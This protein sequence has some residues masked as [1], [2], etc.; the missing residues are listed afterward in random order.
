[1]KKII[2]IVLV[3]MVYG[4]LVVLLAIPENKYDWMQEI[5]GGSSLTLPVDEDSPVV[6]HT[7]SILV[8]LLSFITLLFKNIPKKIR[9]S[10]CVIPWLGVL[11]KYIL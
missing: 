5:S 10:F 1:M 6:V 3:F 8:L 2:Y 11:L 4:L 7:I 9:I